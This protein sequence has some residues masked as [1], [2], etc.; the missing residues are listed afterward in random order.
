[1]NRPPVAWSRTVADF[2]S[3]DGWRNVIDRTPCPSHFPGTWWASVAIAVS[4]SHDGPG[5]LEVDVR[6]VVVHP[7]RVEDV[8]L[9]DPRP[10]AIERRPID[11]PAARS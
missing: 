9:A 7:D 3:T 5:A 8:V 4:A 10:R 2:A 6:Q 11:A 1:M